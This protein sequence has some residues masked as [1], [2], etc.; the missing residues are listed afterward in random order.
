MAPKPLLSL[1]TALKETTKFTVDGKPYEILGIDHL[2][3]EQEAEVVALFSRYGILQ[4]ELSNERN[5][6]KGTPKALEVRATRLLLLS[7]MTT[8][9]SSVAGNMPLSQQVKLLEAIQAEVE[10][11]DDENVAAAAPAEAEAESVPEAT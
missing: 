9:P 6:S 4:E 8:L 3:P 1:S 2:S 11:D 10:A 5:V 7:K